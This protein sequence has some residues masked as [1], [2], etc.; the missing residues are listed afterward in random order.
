MLSSDGNSVESNPDVETE[1]TISTGLAYVFAIAIL[2]GALVGCV[3]IHLAVWGIDG[4]SFPYALIAIFIPLTVAHELLHGVGFRLAGV[5]WSGIRFGFAL[6]RLTPFAHC[7]EPMPAHGYRLSVVLPALVLGL[8]PALAGIAAGLFWL[9]VV[10]ATM[11]GAAG[12]DLAVLWAIRA[13]PGAATVRDHPS[14][15]GCQRVSTLRQA[16]LSL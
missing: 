13:V 14:K 7:K 8:L 1:H 12:G 2:G 4:A 10:G 3:A 11:V 9:T 5:P 6:R 15:V 16:N